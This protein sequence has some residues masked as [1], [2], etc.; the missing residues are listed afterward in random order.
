MLRM[1]FFLTTAQVLARLKWVTRRLKCR[2]KAGDRFL[3]VERLQKVLSL[4]EVVSV[5]REPLHAIEA[6]DTNEE[7]NPET[8]AEGFDLMSGREFVE[9][10]CEHMRC[11]R[12][13]EVFR[14]EF[15]Y[16]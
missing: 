8:Q 13:Q 5:R 4:C 6:A 2:L 15:K 14:I 10:F 16:V 3:A 12:D 1:S 7:F 9:M 11:E